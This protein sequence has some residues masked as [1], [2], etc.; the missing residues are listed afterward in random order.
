MSGSIKPT[1]LN[2][3][4]AIYVAVIVIVGLIAYLLVEQKPVQ[5]PK[6]NIDNAPEKALGLVTDM[7]KLLETLA[8]GL[9]A[10]CIWLLR[11]PLRDDREFVER[12]ILVL[13]TVTA[14]GASMY[15]GFVALDGCLHLLSAKTF[16]AELDPVW[17][18]QTLQYYCFVAAVF[19]LGMACLR[20][21]N[22][23]IAKE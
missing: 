6:P 13:A 10:A 14:L 19:L 3:M 12:A 2:R 23:S 20:S 22:V 4:T 18:P 16:D 8:T 15:F 7:I 11:R 17:W 21:L 9:F 5:L 1:Y